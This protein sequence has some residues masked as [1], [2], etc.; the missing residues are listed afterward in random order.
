M[1]ALKLVCSRYLLLVPS[2]GRIPTPLQKREFHLCSDLILGLA[3]GN[4][5]L[6]HEASKY[7]QVIDCF[8]FPPS[9]VL[10]DSIVEYIWNSWRMA[11]TAGTK[12][13]GT[14][15]KTTIKSNANH[16]HT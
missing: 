3:Q 14:R 5:A 2:S 8:Y 1:Y 4:P 11:R 16:L 6:V 15:T 12:R 7:P 13:R 9:L 10:V